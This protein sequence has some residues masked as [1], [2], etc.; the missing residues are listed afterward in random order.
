MNELGEYTYKNGI[1]TDGYNLP[2]GSDEAEDFVSWLEA[3]GYTYVRKF[4]SVYFNADMY[5]VDIYSGKDTTFFAIVTLSDSLSYF[6]H[7][8]D[9]PSL[10]QFIKDY[11]TSFSTEA[12]RKEIERLTDSI[13]EDI[14]E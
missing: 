11:S 5:R 12:L 7:I 2:Q 10:M 6:V 8:V 9:F 1:W 3:I 14:D 4:G 13:L